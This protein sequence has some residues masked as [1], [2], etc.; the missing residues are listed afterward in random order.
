MFLTY[1]LGLHNCSYKKAL[2]YFCAKNLSSG[3]FLLFLASVRL[4]FA[5]FFLLGGNS[6]PGTFTSTLKQ[7]LSTGGLAP[8][9]PIDI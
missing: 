8:V 3:T 9:H 4:L 5:Q 7:V 6:R 1:R 2:R